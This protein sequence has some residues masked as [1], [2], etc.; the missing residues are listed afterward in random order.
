MDNGSGIVWTC[1][2]SGIPGLLWFGWTKFECSGTIQKI[3]SD[4]DSGIS[5]LVFFTAVIFVGD[6]I[7]VTAINFV[8]DFML[9]GLSG[10]FVN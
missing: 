4:T 10:L 7:V 9:V 8:G 3:S 6:F 2:I 5:S 1:W